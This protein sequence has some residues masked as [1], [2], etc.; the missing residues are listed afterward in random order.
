LAVE[1]VSTGSCVPERVVT[2]EDLACLVDTTDEWIRT[3]TG[4]RERRLACGDGTSDLASAAAQRALESSGVD[5]SLVDLIIA[6]TLTPDCFTPTVSC[7]VQKNLG[8]T[9]ATCFDLWAG[10]TG[11]VF[12]LMTAHSLMESGAFKCALVVGAETLSK[13]TDWTDR[14]TC[15]LFGDGAGAVLLISGRDSGLVRHVSGSDGARGRVLT[16][17]GI[18]ARNPFHSSAPGDHYIRMDGSEVFKFAVRA[19]ADSITQVLDGTGLSTD[20]VSYFVPHQANDRIIDF[21]ANRMGIPR[22]RFYTNLE[23][24]GNT[25]A[26]SIPIALDEMNRAGLLRKGMKLITVG[27]GGGLTWGANLITWTR[28]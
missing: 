24:Y 2:N 18:S 28:G 3:R 17:G 22:G 15:V 19:M 10:C 1:V 13:L 4:I 7:T 21:V 6:A 27:F 5:P 26:A 9:R 11:F 20:D 16:A 14:A 8:L 23:R 25:S 12:S